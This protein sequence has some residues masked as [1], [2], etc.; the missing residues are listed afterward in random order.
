MK[1]PLNHII[2]ILCALSLFFIPVAGVMTGNATSNTTGIQPSGPIQSSVTTFLPT[3][4]PTI[5]I[6][7]VGIPQNIGFLP[8]WLIIGIVLIIIAL[9]G[10][11]W[12]YFHPK[13][14]P[15]EENE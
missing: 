6:P 8:I 5:G 13:Y 4:S 3:T 10:L 2:M 9:G 1:I 12:R 14:V 11:L 7:S 15:K